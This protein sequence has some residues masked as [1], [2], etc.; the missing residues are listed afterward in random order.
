M[1]IS[2]VIPTYN[3]AHFLEKCLFSV[4]CQDYEDYE[5]IIVDDGSTD[6]TS[7][8]VSGIQKKYKSKEIKYLYQENAGPSAARNKGAANA[9]GEYIWCLDSDDALVDG[10]VA[11]MAEAAEN[12]P[13]AWLL[14]SGYR[15]VDENGK[16]ADREPSTLGKDRTENFRRYILKK[17]KGLCTGSALVKSRAFETIGFPADVNINEDLV[18]YAHMLARYPAVSVPGIILT[19]G[20]HQGSQRYKISGMENTGIKAVDRLFDRDLLTP[21]QMGLRNLYL[22]RWYLTLSRAYYRN[23]DYEKARFY[24]KKAIQAKPGFV[25]KWPYLYK[26]IRSILKG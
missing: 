3:Y 16:T 15:S 10:S 1:K 2:F 13:E 20:R 19:V 8:L 17:I 24:Y 7:S 11:Y 18:F 14:F 22:A 21:E 9:A 25:L 6:E 26:Y 23:R 12:H 5:V 4:L